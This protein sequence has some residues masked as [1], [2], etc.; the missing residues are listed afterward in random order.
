MFIS[1]QVPEAISYR[2]AFPYIQEPYQ[3]LLHSYSVHIHDL[4]KELTFT[5]A[6]SGGSGGQHVNK[7]ETKVVLMFS[8]VD[9]EMLDD[10]EKSKIT[11]ALKNRINKDGVLILAYD[12]KRSQRANRRAVT[13]LFQVLIEQALRPQKKRKPTQV[14]ASVKAQRRQAKAQRSS[15]KA[16]RKKPRL[17]D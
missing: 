7:V 15:V 16:M 2:L 4:H 6:R 13:K 12:R 10:Q 8:V 5:T 1:D 11:S 9:S 14:P 17:D 3:S